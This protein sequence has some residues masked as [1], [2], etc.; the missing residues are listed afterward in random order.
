MK[1][2]ALTALIALVFIGCGSTNPLE[3]AGG[4]Y[5]FFSGLWDGFTVLFAFI[6]KMFGADWNIYEVTNNGNWYNFGFL[7]GS[8]GF[9]ILSWFQVS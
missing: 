7:I 9:G 1:T 4:N 2:L 6:G 3:G 8:G 5:G